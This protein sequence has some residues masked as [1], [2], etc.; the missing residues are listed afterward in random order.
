MSAPIETVADLI[1]EEVGKLMF[2]YTDEERGQACDFVYFMLCG[3][4]VAPQK[5]KEEWIHL[6]VREFLELDM[7]N[8]SPP[9]RAAGRALTTAE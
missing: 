2:S 1:K 5:F 8:I 6:A 3:G 4:P 7:P 9:E